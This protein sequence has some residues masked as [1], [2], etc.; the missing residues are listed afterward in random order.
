MLTVDATRPTTPPAWAVLERRLIDAID[1]AAPVFLEKYTRSGGGL[2]MQEEYPGDGV[3][4]DDLYEAFFNWPLYHALGGSDYCGRKAVEEWD[5]ITR[6]IT[7]DYGRAHKEFISDDD[8]FHNGENYIYFYYLGLS[9]P[10]NRD[11]VSRARRFAGF[12]MNE[13]PEVPNYDAERRLVRSPFSGSKGPLF[14]A[15]FADVRYNLEHRHTTLGPGYDYP[16]DWQDRDDWREKIHAKFDEVVMRGDVTVNL[17]VVPL[18]ATAFL[19]TG[20]QKYR[21]WIVA[22]AD[23]WLERTTQNGGIVPD[24]VGHGGIIG[25]T[26]GGQWWGGFYGWTGRYGHQM[27]GAA[28]TIASEAACLVT[29]ETRFL[30]LLRGHLDVLMR[31][32]A[33][34]GGRLL[35]PHNF[36]GEWTNFGPIIPHPPVH[37]WAA[38]MAD[39]DWQRLERLRQGCEGEWGAMTSRGPR[40]HDDRAWTR[41][42]AGELPAYPELVLQANYQEVRRRTEIILNDDQDLTRI[43]VHH[44]QQV[45]PVVTEA[46]VHLTTGGPETIYWGGLAR[47][48]VR[49]FDPCG[50]RPGLPPDVAALVSALRPDGVELTLVNLDVT[51]ERRV[52]VGAGSFGEH[53]FTTVA[54]LG[55]DGANAESARPVDGTYFEVALPPGCEIRIAAGMER[56]CQEPS[57]AFPWHNDGLLVT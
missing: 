48:C 53:R 19:F 39:E 9:D 22:Y 10:R 42:L 7:Y 25:E 51:A 15:R 23:S 11:T 31:N 1:E 55:A 35:V 18:V 36:D 16:E 44:W 27:M 43:D 14:H 6:Q 49:Y 8:W 17:A 50:C 24:N 56:Y 47:G 32:G 37:L 4:A 12:Y 30:E 5:A 45:N 13:D 54:E 3:W 34:E 38:S 52:I 26:R 46:L 21:D 41:Y 29:G 28:I 2:I 33:D 20:E 57:Y 40:S